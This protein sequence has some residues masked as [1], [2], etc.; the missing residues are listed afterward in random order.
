MELST[1]VD[2]RSRPA[3]LVLALAL[4]VVAIV[5]FRKEK[6]SIAVL[7]GVGAAALGY[8][9]VTGSS[10]TDAEADPDESGP[11]TDTADT[12]DSDPD[13]MRCAICGEPI[14]VGQSRRPN[15][16]NEIVHEACLGV[17]E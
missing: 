15:P 17:S 2:R 14:V 12:A 11:E 7:S 4:A 8:T 1:D 10:N 16:N 5:S 9:A 3:R 13:E 6:R